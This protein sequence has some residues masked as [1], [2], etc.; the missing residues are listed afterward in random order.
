MGAVDTSASPG[1]RVTPARPGL[2]YGARPAWQLYL[3][4][5]IHREHHRHVRREQ[6]IG[7]SWRDSTGWLAYHHDGLDVPGRP[8]PIPVTVVFFE[9]PPYDTYGITSPNYPRVWADCGA[10]SPHRMPDDALC[11]WWP[12]SP[13]EQQWTADDGLLPLLNLVRD[14]LFFEHY[15]RL[16]GG[17]PRGRW[18][19]AEAPHGFATRMAS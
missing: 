9:S 12:W 10:V 18:L 19:G 1:G 17:H 11:L 16:T 5:G 2:W 7:V 15:W 13:V 3:E 8:A 6:G 4:R 14:H